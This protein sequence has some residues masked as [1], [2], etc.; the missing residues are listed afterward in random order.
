MF[1]YIYI[2]KKKETLWVSGKYIKK[3]AG[4][5]VQQL[6][7]VTLVRLGTDVVGSSPAACQFFFIYIYDKVKEDFKYQKERKILKDEVQQDGK[8][9]NTS[10]LGIEPGT[11]A[12]VAGA[13][14]TELP[15]PGPKPNQNE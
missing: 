8:N 5:V 10:Q 3:K 11:P 1:I 4:R 13:L 15:G 9:A 14:P 6:P 7:S 2:F 12:D